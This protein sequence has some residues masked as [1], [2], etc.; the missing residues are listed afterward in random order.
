MNIEPL[1]DCLY[2]G[3]LGHT[4]GKWQILRSQSSTETHHLNKEGGEYDCMRV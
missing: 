1:F 2:L 3:A 4:Q